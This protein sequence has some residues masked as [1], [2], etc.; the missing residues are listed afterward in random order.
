MEQKSELVNMPKVFYKNLK[1]VYNPRSDYGTDEFNDI[2]ES[3]RQKGVF[4]PIGVKKNDSGELEVVFGHRRVK[5][6]TQIIMEESLKGTPESLEIINRVK[7][8]PYILET[9]NDQ[10]ID[11][12][13]LEENIHHKGFNAVEEAL[14]F[15]RYIDTYKV[16]SEVL[17]KKISKPLIYVEKRLALLNLSEDIQKAIISKKIQVGHG[18]ILA[19]VK[20][21]KKKTELFNSIIKDNLS[22][23]DAL[24]VVEQNSDVCDLNNAL[25]SLDTCQGCK[26]NF[27]N[28]SMLISEGATLKNTCN[29]K[30]CFLKK[31][32]EVISKKEDEL[33]T[34]GFNIIKDEDVKNNIIID[35]DKKKKLGNKFNDQCVN[36]KDFCVNIRQK[37][38]LLEIRGVCK[39]S[40]CFSPKSKVVKESP[41]VAALK[42]EVS[43]EEKAKTK[44][45]QSR[46]AKQN[47]KKR[48]AEYKKVVLQKISAEKT[49]SN[50]FQEKC[51]TLYALIK[52]TDNVP[53]D[54]C[55]DLG[56]AKSYDLQGIDLKKVL[57]LDISEVER[58]INVFT[59]LWTKD[60]SDDALKHY[61]DA[62]GVN[63][64][65]DYKID[66]EFLEI[67]LKDQLKDIACEVGLD[68]HY[69]ELNKK[70]LPD[71]KDELINAFLDT[72]FNLNVTPE[73][74]VKA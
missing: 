47:Q 40:E 73:I 65:T 29:N 46:L 71:K 8:I 57:N 66:K 34:Q 38:N 56:F 42:V 16:S 60:L 63:I 51:L 24:D 30:P 45:E 74:M 55:K 13:K 1:V 52:S 25:F 54:I 28:Q 68:K 43:D 61:S 44:Q 9:K 33:K 69:F 50:S 53:D 36:C 35:E 49:V 12:I 31:N 26:N 58:L 37:T 67:N 5:C 20:D 10:E 14:A 2:K 21:E 48:V 3:I 18:L 72:G 17:A 15:K 6:V 62:V 64:E 23:Q 41:K 7:D 39:N 22:V 27:G 59:K 19:N 70:K 32:R 11:E 4:Q